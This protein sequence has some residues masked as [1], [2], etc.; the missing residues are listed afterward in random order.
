MNFKE[1]ACKNGGLVFRVNESPFPPYDGENKNFANWESISNC[2]AFYQ[3]NLFKQAM[4][5]F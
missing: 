5:R 4:K 2:L 3:I 1:K